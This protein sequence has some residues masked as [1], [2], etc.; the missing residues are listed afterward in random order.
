MNFTDKQFPKEW[1]CSITHEIMKVPVMAEDGISYEKEA[2]EKWLETSNKSPITGTQITKEGLTINYALKNTIEQIVFKKNESII[3]SSTWSD[4]PHTDTKLVALKIPH[5]AKTYLHLK[6]STPVIA[7]AK[8]TLALCLIDISGSMGCEASINEKDGETHGFSRL[9]LVKHSL[10]TI[11]KSVNDKVELGL[12]P[13]SEKADV[14]LEPTKM[15]ET[16]KSKVSDLVDQLKP[17][18]TTNIWDALRLALEI[19]KNP[20]HNNKNIFILLFTDGVPNNNPPRGIKATLERELKKNSLNATINT[21]GFG[22]ELDST[23]LRDISDMGLGSYSFIPDATMV[24]TVFVNFIA[25]TLLT[26]ATNQTINV[27]GEKFNWEANIGSLQYGQDKDVIIE[28]PNIDMT[29]K[30]GDL[31]TTVSDETLDTPLFQE[32]AYQ[33]CRKEIIDII[34]KLIV[35]NLNVSH[36]SISDSTD[37]INDLYTQLT[38]SFSG[39][40][41]IEQLLKDLV[42]DKEDEGQI[43]KAV[44][45]SDWYTKWGKHYLLS[46]QNAHLIQQCNNFKDPGVQLYGGE[47]FSELRDDIEDIFCKIPPPKPTARSFH[48]GAGGA[49]NVVG[50]SSMATYMNAGG[51]C[52]NGDANIKMEDGTTKNVNQ[53]QRGDIV[54][55]GHTIRCL[56]STTV[57]GPI[58]MVEVNSLLITPWH[59]I[60]ID[61]WV[62]PIKAFVSKTVE[63]DKIYNIVLES[64]HKVILNDIMVVTLG[65]GFQDNSVL[66]HDYYG[67]EKVINDLRAMDGWSEGYVELDQMIVSRGPDG[68]VSSI[69]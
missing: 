3:D 62:F 35:K 59:P 14:L 30:F 6:I 61:E 43:T 18:N 27:T 28:T 65:H 60:F 55:G 33:Y 54:Y 16:E 31:T 11:I 4:L 64:D 29:V 23:L 38:E 47:K 22:Y 41:K 13:F 20:E 51:G 37:I 49:S 32:F 24:G 45:R 50:V 67:T 12:I 69:S 26:Y 9:D 66:K 68:N 63:L 53:L 39:F 57:N 56:V 48:Y 15:I 46:I 7:E 19:V 34:G 42:S 25:N 5:N 58:E 44:S 40:E 17:T 2:I 10:K 1:Y 8:E 52:F 21:F 36:Q